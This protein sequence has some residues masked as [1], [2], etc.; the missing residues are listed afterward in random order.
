MEESRRESGENSYGEILGSSTIVG[1]SRAVT[2]VLVLARTKIVAILLGPVGVGLIGLYQSTIGL[3]ATASGLG[4]GSSGVREVASAYADGDDERIAT[5]VRTLRRSCVV[6]GA[7]GCLLTVVVA[8]PLSRWAFG[9]EDHA[10]EMALLGITVLLTTIHSGQAALLQGTRRIAKLASTTVISAAASTIVA[11]VVYWFFGTDGIVPVLIANAAIQVL[12]FWWV[13]RHIAVRRVALRWSQTWQHAKSLLELG[14]AFMWGALLAAAV[15]L[16]LRSV[17]VRELGLGAAGIYTSSWGLSGMFASFV[18][19][20]MGTDFYPRLTAVAQDNVSVNRLVNEQIEIGV[21]LALPG[22][23]GTQSF[24]PFVMQLFYSREFV[25][26]AELLQWFVLGVMLQVVAWP[27][28]FIQ[29]AKGASRWMYVSQTEAQVLLL[30]LSVGL[31]HHY[32]DVIGVAVALPCMYAIHL[33]VTILIARHLSSFRYTSN[34][35]R[36]QQVALGLTL[37]GFFVQRWLPNDWAV[38]VGALI[39]V[40][41]TYW[42]LREI[43][44]RIGE[45]HRVVRF[46]RKLPGGKLI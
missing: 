43:T 4:I 46:I 21:L 1:G 38:A 16:T 42:S 3:V 35:F 36:L 15:A 41:A 34:A 12:L 14:L 22:L 8:T 27:L 32:D 26:G 39:T 20:A 11:I 10:V 17:I 2:Y 25:G 5:T 6:A 44:R 18:L 33:V 13:A 23:V 24:A 28:G 30:G 37:L 45:E 19:A 40:G 31:L 29:R 7:V 9:D